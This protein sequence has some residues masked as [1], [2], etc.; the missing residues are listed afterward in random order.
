M[1]TDLPKYFSD[2]MRI[3]VERNGLYSSLPQVLN[4]FSAMAFGLLSDICINKEYLS[5]KNTRRIF[6]T[7][8]EKEIK[9]KF[10]IV[11]KNFSSRHYG[12]RCLLHYGILLWL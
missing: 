5:V 12:S 11:N 6:T 7:A 10:K 3:D 8:G 1:T 2:V 9:N 4:F